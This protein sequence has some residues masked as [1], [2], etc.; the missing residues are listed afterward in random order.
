MA[1]V[2]ACWLNLKCEM[3]NDI[4]LAFSSKIEGPPEMAVIENPNYNTTAHPFPPVKIEWRGRNTKNASSRWIFLRCCGGIGFVDPKTGLLETRQPCDGSVPEGARLHPGPLVMVRTSGNQCR[5]GC[6]A[7]AKWAC[8]GAIAVPRWESTWDNVGA[9]PASCW[10]NNHCGVAGSKKD[11]PAPIRRSTADAK[12]DA[13]IADEI[14]FDDTEG[15]ESEP[16]EIDV[17]GAK[18]VEV[19]GSG[20][21]T[22]SSPVNSREE[23]HRKIA[24]QDFLCGRPNDGFSSTPPRFPAS[25]GFVSR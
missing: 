1:G 13:V 23:E 2:F 10:I 3:K 8:C 11:A 22:K 16:D 20:G 6:D 9:L 5:K 15:A 12:E 18:E 24:I 21:A 17:F 25:M 7:M 4:R 19:T 14:A